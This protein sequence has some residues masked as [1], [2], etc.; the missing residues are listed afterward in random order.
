MTA[1]L[2][3][4][5]KGQRIVQ[6]N[7]APNFKRY[8]RMA[9]DVLARTGDFTADSI[10]ETAEHIAQLEGVAL[11]PHHANLLPAVIGGEVAAGRIYR[12]GEYHSARVSRR[13][14]RNSIYRA[15]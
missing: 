8:F 1:G 14:G 15:T 7:D 9:I 5:S 2:D 13:Y 3:L 11:Q 12:V 10:R 6:A 4:R